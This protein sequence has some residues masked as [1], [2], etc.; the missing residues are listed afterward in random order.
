MSTYHIDPRSALAAEAADEV[1]AFSAD[2]LIAVRGQD[3]DYGD[4]DVVETVYTVSACPNQDDT[5]SYC[6][7]YV[8]AGDW[9]AE[10]DAIQQETK[11]MSEKQLTGFAEACYDTNTVAELEAA[12]EQRAADTTDCEI[13]EITPTQWR[14]A[15]A[16][17]LAAKLEDA[18][19]D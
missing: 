6:W 14:A 3:F 11:T 18:G 10:F 1:R 16:E 19:G 12:L 5:S 13:W 7:A 8:Q 2:T 4:G 9:I 17:A 15:I